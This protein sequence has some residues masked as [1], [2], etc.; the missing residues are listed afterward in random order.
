MLAHARAA[1]G[2]RVKGVVLIDQDGRGD[3]APFRAAGFDAYLVRPVRLQ[4]L[5]GQLGLEPAVQPLP[6][7]APQPPERS[8]AV[9]RD[10]SRRLLLVEDNDINALL[11]RRVSEKAGCHVTH[12]RSGAA[13]LSHAE[14]VLADPEQI[15]HLV[16]MDIHM[17]EMDGFE[18]ARRLRQ[19]FTAAGRTSPPVV[20]LTANAFAEDRKRCLE[21]GFDDFLAKPFDRSELE[22]LLDK[23][24]A[25]PAPTRGGALDE[26][27]A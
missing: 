6:L 16:L 25:G 10:G 18:A 3:L 4:S 12:A 24:C 14:T 9:L 15:V 13:A 22:A 17:P 23:W 7:N 11:A 1:Q 8:P 21:A 20:A 2:R 5:I 26:F 27:A 19:L